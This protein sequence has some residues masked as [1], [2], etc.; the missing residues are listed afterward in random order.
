MYTILISPSLA[1]QSIHTSHVKK[2][3]HGAITEGETLEREERGEKVEDL[4]VLVQT[5]LQPC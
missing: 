2:F 1:M 4:H 3:Y 5:D